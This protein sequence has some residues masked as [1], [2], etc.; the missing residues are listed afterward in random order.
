MNP[1]M[2]SPTVAH[3]AGRPAALVLIAFCLLLAAPLG[4]K[5]STRH[6]VDEVDFI[7]DATE[8]E[9]E[10]EIARIS[11]TYGQDV[12]ILYRNLNEGESPMAVA[13]DYFDYE[14]YGL[15]AE[16]SGVL[17]LVSPST[18]DWWISTRGESIPTFTDKGIKALGE[19]L[20]EPLGDDEWEQAART[21]VAQTERY[22]E[23]ARK[24]APITSAPKTWKD[25]LTQWGGALAVGVLGGFGAG[26]GLVRSL[27]VSK[28]KN[29]GL[30][31]AASSYVRSDALQIIGGSD[32]FITTNTTR[33]ARPES[34]SESSSGSSTHTS[35]SGATHGGGGGKF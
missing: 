28:M 20:T 18:R 2:S 6:V 4:A 5:A 29:E 26:R 7:S 17:L 27:F 24:G 1:T 10:A 12:V 9:L 25:R 35:S 16:R 14:G 30:E 19:I 15:G 32:V 31:P 8:A 3:R 33:T 13:D 21:Y 22:M 11:K 23:A 34:S